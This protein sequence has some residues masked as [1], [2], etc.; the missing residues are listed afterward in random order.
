MA[1]LSDVAERGASQHVFPASTIGGPVGQVR[2]TPRELVELDGTGEELWEGGSKVVGDLLF[3]EPFL[4]TYRC[5]VRHPASLGARGGIHEM[6]A[7]PTRRDCEHDSDRDLDEV[8]Q[9][10]TGGRDH[11][12][13]ALD[14]DDK[15]N[16][17]DC[18]QSTHG[19]P[20][21]IDANTCI[22]DD[23]INQHCEEDCLRDR[24]SSARN[25]AWPSSD[26]PAIEQRRGRAGHRRRLRHPRRSGP[27]PA[28]GTS[29][30][31]HAHRDDAVGNDQVEGCR[32]TG[33]DGEH[34]DAGFAVIG[35]VLQ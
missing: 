30:R 21:P 4:R 2:G 13:P 17:H 3:V 32:L 14:G 8:T 23:S 33:H 22:E 18:R 31:L 9:P 35:L 7:K 6:T 26:L 24:H 19:L 5:G 25:S 12:G 1:A 28:A 10:R 11:P 29:N 16:A 34:G 27:M 15:G 20:Q